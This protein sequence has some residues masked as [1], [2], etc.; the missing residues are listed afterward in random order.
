VSS[1]VTGDRERLSELAREQAALRRIATLVARGIPAAEIFDAVAE[2]VALLLGVEAAGILPFEPDGYATVVGRWGPLAE[3]MFPVGRRI[4][5]D[6][7][8][9]T[10]L[11]FRTQR[12]ARIDRY[13]QASGA[14]AEE[15]QELGVRSAVASPVVVNGR[16][17]GAI[18]AA[19]ARSESMPADAESRIA[20]FTELVATAISNVEARAE[21]ERLAE[22]QAALRRVATMV[23]HGCPE[24]DIFAQVAREL[25]LLL[26]VD[27]AG[28]RRYEPDGYATLV[29]TW[30]KRGEALPAYHRKKLEEDGISTSVYWTKRPVRSD[31]Q[32]KEAPIHTEVH[33]LGMRSAVASPIVV[34]GRL[35]GAIGV[36]TMRAE[37]LPP[38]TELRIKQFT[39]LVATAIAN[40]QARSD[41]AASRARIV[42]AAD[43]ERRRVVRD[44]HDGAQ[45][46]LV[47]TV[48]TLKLANRA[49]ERGQDA[50]ALVTQ[51]LEHAQTATDELRELAH[52][53]L[54]SVL[55]DG[56][57][58]AGVTA[59]ASRSSI[60][61]NTN[62][63]VSRL[64]SAVEATA[65]FIV[66]EA[67]TNVAKYSHAQV[68]EVTVR[69]RND[70]L[71]V[72]IRDDGVGGARPDGSGLLGLRDR[73]EA[74]RG[75]LTIDSPDGHG[76]TLVAKLPLDDTAA[77]ARVR[78]A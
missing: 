74:L 25:G 11:A 46:R 38:D 39:E 57:L 65:Y 6:G 52:G 47:H 30:G 35:W 27:I 45:Q 2:E 1:R 19:S 76:T 16:R 48:V 62:I 42:A 59:L 14:T 31:D 8:S 37:P 7:N 23:A 58:S 3:D 53:I 61:I 5:L 44:L 78:A 49:L 18:V 28:I 60:P 15:L 33:R 13:E 54:P 75:T 36:A 4:T 20:Q 24:E 66:A 9:A 22:E 50:T 56:G 40:V 34:G 51:A 77:P 70:T 72:R 67:L 73:V 41:L 69:M 32:P 26:G 29:G 63:S 68:A 43:E 12:S 21:V 55:T 64:P 17:W 71:E 10:A